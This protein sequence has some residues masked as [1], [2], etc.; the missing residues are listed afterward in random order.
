[1]LSK[2]LAIFLFFELSFMGLLGLTMVDMHHS[3]GHVAC[4]FSMAGSVCIAPLASL[5]VDMQMTYIF[6]FFL[7]VINLFIFVYVS[8]ERLR[9]IYRY[10]LRHRFL[11]L[12]SILLS[13][14]LMHS[15]VF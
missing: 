15:K 5:Q 4:P 6:A 3:V 9:F 12:N 13:D 8:L 10:R 1:M 7:G 11:S 2:L 14:G